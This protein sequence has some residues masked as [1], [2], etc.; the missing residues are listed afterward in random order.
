[1]EGREGGYLEN[2]GKAPLHIINE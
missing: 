2:V 1:M